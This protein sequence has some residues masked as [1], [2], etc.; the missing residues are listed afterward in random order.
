GGNFQSIGSSCAA[1][2]C[3]PSIGACCI[4]GSCVEIEEAVCLSASG[5]FGGAGVEC[6]SVACV[7]PCPEDLDN[8]GAVDFNDILSLLAAWGPCGTCDEDIDENGTVD[9]ADLLVMLAAYG[10]C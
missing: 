1:V 7:Q 8:N 5:T 9:F 2:D 6:G 3:T 4:D 10:D